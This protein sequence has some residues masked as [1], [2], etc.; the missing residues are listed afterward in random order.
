MMSM[1]GTGAL[2][3]SI[4][5]LT[6]PEEEREG[7]IALAAGIVLVTLSVL[8]WSR[9][10]WVSAAAVAFQSLSISTSLGLASIIIQEMVPD[11]LRG[12]V[13]SLSSLMFTGVMPFSS[14]LITSLAD[15]IGMRRE[16]QISAVLYASGAL[17]LLCR[18]RGATDEA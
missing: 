4:L 8:A 16:L 15:G 17:L 2:V 14:L 12:R 11:V 5:L 10:L 13:M 1:S 9:H 7:R 18:L 6:V 3:G